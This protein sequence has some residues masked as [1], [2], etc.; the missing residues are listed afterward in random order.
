MDKA[1]YKENINRFINDGISKG[2]YV[3]EENDNTL[4]ELKSFQSFF[5]RNLGKHEKYKEMRSIS[6]QPARLF[7]TAKTH[8]NDLKLRLII[9]QT[10]THLYDC[11]KVIAQYLQPLAINEFTIS[12]TL[13]FPYIFRE[14]SLDSNEEY[15]SCDLDSLFTSIPLGETVDFI[16]DEIYVRKK[17]EPFCK[18]SVFKRLLNKLCKGCTFV[19]DGR[20]I[21]QVDG[22]PMGG[23]ISVVFCNIFCVKRE[24]DVV[25]PLKPKLYKRYVD[26]IYSKRIKNQPHKH[27]EKLNNYHPNIKLTIEVNPSKFLD[28]EIM[29]KNGIIETS[30]AVK[31]SKIPNHWSSAVLKK[32]KRNAILG[33]LHRAHKISSNLELEKQGIR[34]KCLSF[35]FP[36]NFIHSTFSSYQQNRKSLI[37]N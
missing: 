22:C 37:P 18:K 9:D 2:V 33:D 36:Y 24:F 15:V 12:G 23:P 16:L 10:G 25:K 34:K 17:L 35:N 27:F 6:S 13:S 31:E 14:N 5:Y 8:I 30:V 20:L 7:S 29:I 32:Y 1:C 21:R 4:E 28:I 11:S 3:I 26:D 19:A